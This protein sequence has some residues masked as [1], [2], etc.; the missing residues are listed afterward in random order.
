[1]LGTDLKLAWQFF[2][3]EKNS[4]QQRFLR[5][6]QGILMVFA[7]TLSLTSE[8]I[9]RY[10]SDN[11]DNLLGADLVMILPHALS[12]EQSSALAHFSQRSI[13]AQ[14]VKTTL[15]HNDKW[16]RIKLKAVSSEY[17]LQGA[18]SIADSLQGTERSVTSGPSRGEIWLDSRTLTSLSLSVGNTVAL[19][20][21][22]FT[23]SQVLLYEPDRLMEGHSVDMRAMIHQDDLPALAFPVDLIEHRY[24]VAATRQA[25]TDILDWQKQQLPSA[26]VYHKQGAHPLAL[27]WQRTEN[28]IGLASVILFFMS[29]IAI[30]QLSHV[31]AR[32][33]Q[34]LCAVSMSLG[35]SK[36]RSLRMSALKWGF[37]LVL[38]I[39]A[40]LVISA[41]CHWL[42]VTWL[43]DTF[44][45]LG[46]QWHAAVALRSIL[47]MS[48]LLLIF[49]FPVW[50]GLQHS[51]VSQLV[52]N[53]P[54]K[55]SAKISKGSVVV[56]L[57]AVAWAFSDNAL[58]TSMLLGAA[59]IS[60]LLILFISWG[61]LT[62]GEKVTQGISGLMPFALYMMKQRL[63]SKSTQILGVGL[64]AFLLLFT[65][66][67]LRDLGNTMAAYQRQHDGNLLVSQAT[68]AQMA[69]VQRWSEQNGAEVRQFKPFIYAKLIEVNG[70][71]LEEFSQTPSESLATLG[72]AIR[73]HWS[74]EVPANNRV[75]NGQ[76]W[77][78]GD[79][80]WQQI[81]VEQ[82]VL[83]DLGLDIGDELTFYI[84]QQAIA[85]RIAASH[86][87]KPGAGSITFWIQMPPS[88]R[89][90]LQAPEYGMASLEVP[91]QRFSRLGELWQ[92]H[93]SLRMVSLKELT[94]RFDTTLA[95]VTQVI[96][97]FS[98]L[99]ILL[100][101]IAIL[102]SI[103]ALEVREKR[104]NCIVMSFGFTRKTCLRLNGIEWLV[105]GAIAAIGAIAGTY[106]A[107]VLIYQSQFQLTYQPD[108]LWLL[109]TL[110]IIL[111]TITG[112]GMLASRS[113]LSGS[114][115]ELLADQR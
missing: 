56:V 66:M 13:L 102:A 35:A 107:G 6:I 31:Q 2:H 95:M 23:V 61:A 12:D 88:A 98:G 21:Q 100:A 40:V 46:W 54:G 33:E 70:T 29:A 115:R 38:L 14:T 73:M 110:A 109:A 90:H 108:A 86:V 19:A 24:M 42:I 22:P 87:F 74:D 101:V 78:S 1:M 96:S 63:V 32:K 106:I 51:S 83:I 112:L 45:Q 65:L 44:T 49:Q 114:V 3:Q 28:V 16:Q 59:A 99:I 34:F 68:E 52:K 79:T 105:T 104:K 80:T 72:R 75:Q 55:L 77:Q 11:L 5:W 82:E 15:T 10:L 103:H 36:W 47:A 81:S 62:L 91:E 67:L 58:L 41:G 37:N 43:A 26:Q 64:C 20:G 113:S 85:F 94:A 71:S 111:T 39:P 27:F 18:I 30:E 4:A 50:W 93:P 92:R 53:T 25:I 60:V 7:L 69:D 57:A 9:Q 17:P 97:G 8:S 76:W 84:A 89:A 48:L